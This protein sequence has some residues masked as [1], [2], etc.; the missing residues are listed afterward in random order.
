MN[1][2]SAALRGGRWAVPPSGI[3]PSPLP[4]MSGIDPK[5]YA[6]SG[7]TASS[8]KTRS[9]AIIAEEDKIDVSCTR[10]EVR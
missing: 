2:G 8:L 1:A 9:E 3:T 10:S 6:E 5:T 4:S 7:M